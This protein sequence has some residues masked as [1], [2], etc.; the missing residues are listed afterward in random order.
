MRSLTIHNFPF[1]HDAEKMSGP[2]RSIM[3]NSRAPPHQCRLLHNL[4]LLTFETL[5]FKLF[6][7]AD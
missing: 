2:K 4:Q 7:V 5:A 1:I 3:I 6:T